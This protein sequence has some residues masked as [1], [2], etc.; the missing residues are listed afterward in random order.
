M[1]SGPD[2]GASIARPQLKSVRPS[3]VPSML[4]SELLA[5]RPD[6]V[7]QRWR[8]ESLRK[9]IDVAKAQFYPTINLNGLIGL[10]TLGFSKFLQGSSG[11]ASAGAGLSLPIF[12]GGR[13]RGN[14][15][16][17]DADYDLAVEAYNQTLV[18]A[19]RDV[20]S[21][22]VSIQWLAE[23]NALQ[24]EAVATAQQA[25][26]LSVQRYRSGVGNYLQVLAAQIQVLAQQRGQIDLDTRAFDLDMQLARAL[27]GGYQNVSNP[28]QQA[29]SSR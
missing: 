25:Y 28:G 14:L 7:A 29:I 9:D 1:G 16:L 27:G 23:R 21:Q 18:D 3:A 19:L 4:P 11:I 12:D 20:V 13:L 2:R 24:A 22:L 15:A 5:R 26:D 6:V 8:V 17:H 10:Q